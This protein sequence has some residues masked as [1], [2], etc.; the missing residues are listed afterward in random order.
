M[1]RNIILPLIS[2]LFYILFFGGCKKSEAKLE[3]ENCEQIQQVKITG[4][5]TPPYYVGDTISLATNLVPLSLFRWSQTNKPNDIS[6]GATVFIN[7]C[8]KDDEGWYYLNVSYPE[9][10][11][12]NDSVYISV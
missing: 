1:K 11:Y 3:A 9:C 2:G 12:H 7:S 4:A 6:N 8:T 10:A 5:K